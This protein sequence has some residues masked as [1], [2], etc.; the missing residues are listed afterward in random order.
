ME[1]YEYERMIEEEADRQ[2]L[3]SQALENVYEDFMRRWLDEHEDEIREAFELIPFEERYALIEEE[4]S[5]MLED[6]AFERE[7]D[8][9][10]W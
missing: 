6:A 5:R 1:L 8:G 7:N 9:V 4:I 3:E 10:P 2:A